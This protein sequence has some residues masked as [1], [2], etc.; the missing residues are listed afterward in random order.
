MVAEAA[1]VTRCYI[2][3]VL[4]RSLSTFLDCLIAYLSKS[5]WATLEFPPEFLFLASLDCLF[6]QSRS[7]M[8]YL[9]TQLFC[10]NAPPH[11]MI[12]IPTSH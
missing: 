7:C 11:H 12:E 2:L 3:L 4:L 5:K 1:L 6:L 9:Q 10:V 8:T